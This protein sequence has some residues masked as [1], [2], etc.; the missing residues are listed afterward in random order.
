MILK[1][2]Q[3]LVN[4]Y[5][6]WFKEKLCVENINGICEITTPF[7]DRHNDYLQIYVKRSDSRLILTDDGYTINDLRLSGYEFTSSE[8]RLQIF[9]SILNGFGVRLVNNELVIEASPDNFPQKK[10]NLLQTILAINDLFVLSE[11]LVGR[12][13]KEDVARYLQLHQIRFTPSVKFA[14][15]SGF[16]HSFDFVIPASQEKPERVLQAINKPDK[17]NISILMFSWSI[18]TKEV[19]APDSTAYGI[20]ND[21]DRIIN[22]E[23]TSALKQYGVNAIPWSRRDE[24]VKELAA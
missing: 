20:L 6:D 5:V 1:D 17:Q 24:Y 23:F 18:D 15:K 12:I 10:H 2:C 9:N 16:D 13:F 19:R 21:T 8:K 11:P 4:T 22:P 3:D 7:V 14:G